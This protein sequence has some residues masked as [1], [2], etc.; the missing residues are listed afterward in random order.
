ML[1]ASDR[2]PLYIVSTCNRNGQNTGGALAV[3]KGLVGQ[4]EQLVRIFLTTLSK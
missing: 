3:T 1:Q 4:V 2:A